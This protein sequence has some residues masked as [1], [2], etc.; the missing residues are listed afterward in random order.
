LFGNEPSL[1]IK[2]V[3]QFKNASFGTQTDLS[4]DK[5]L[6]EVEYAR[7]YPAQGIPV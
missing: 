7:L 4:F 1:S 6:E 5:D 3:R 2:P